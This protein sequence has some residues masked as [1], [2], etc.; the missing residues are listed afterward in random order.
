MDAA[1]AFSRVDAAYESCRGPALENALLAV[2]ADC[3]AE[4]GEASPLYAAMCSEL[5]GYYRGQARYAESEAAFLRAVDILRVDPGEESPDYTTALNNLAG[6]YRCMGK[7]EE[8]ERL[9]LRC[10]ER[11][12]V[13]PGR[14][15]VLYASALNN[16][17][18][19]CL[20]R[21]ELGRAEELLA[22]SAAVLSALPACRDEY[23]SA[24]CNRSALLLRLGR[25]EE[26]VPLLRE[27]V[28]LYEQKLG[29]DTPHYHAALN[30]LGLAELALHDVTA[31]AESFRRAVSAAEALY[32]PEHPE[33][34]SL[35]R[36]LAQV[37]QRQEENI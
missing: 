18:L 28:A 29:T 35:R 17:A 24:L 11:Y 10:L 22:Q 36:T 8:A 20:D 2:A 30:S 4:N 15:H 12:A 14:R 5:G 16:Y 3:A 19:L 21:G 9:F 13:S 23:A 27:A 26:A 7:Y 31:A 34:R 33:T 6:T 1:T 25:A 32:G 37:K